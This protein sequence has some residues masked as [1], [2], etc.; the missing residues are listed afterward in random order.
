MV[1][2]K[3]VDILQASVSPIDDWTSGET[4]D[5]RNFKWTLYQRA[6]IEVLHDSIGRMICPAMMC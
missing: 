1:L 2:R 4:E 3:V 5:T 6:S